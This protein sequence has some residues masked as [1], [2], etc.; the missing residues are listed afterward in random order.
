[1]KESERLDLEEW[2]TRPLHIRAREKLWS[3]FGEV[4]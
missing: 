1:L 4:F 2:R 3:F